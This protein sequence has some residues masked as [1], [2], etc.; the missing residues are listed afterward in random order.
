MFYQD[1]GLRITIASVL[2]LESIQLM[3]LEVP[4][5]EQYTDS[6]MWLGIQMSSY[7]GDKMWLVQIK[8]DGQSCCVT[9]EEN[10]LEKFSILINLST[11]N[12]CGY[13]PT[14][15]M[16]SDVLYS[17]LFGWGD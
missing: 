14:L 17:Y 12:V 4:L 16:K 13:K 2:R 7:K 5:R 3:V 9:S 1:Y 15:C 8:N 11:P 10:I 6:Y